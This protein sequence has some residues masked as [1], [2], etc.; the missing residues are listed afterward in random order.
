MAWEKE[1][2][3]LDVRVPDGREPLRFPA[4]LVLPAKLTW[5]RKDG[6]AGEGYDLEMD[7][8]FDGTRY[9]CRA[10]RLE[11]RDGGAPVTTEALRE[12]PVK[13][14][15]KTALEW[16]VLEWTGPP[17][18][19]QIARSR[20]GKPPADLARGGMT[21]EALRWVVQIHEVATVLGDPPTKS[22]QDELGI[23]RAT[24]GRWVAEARRRGMLPPADGEDS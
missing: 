17:G 6:P 9:V 14:M 1:H 22:V 20:P 12:V 23:S 21:D 8:A 24:A 5:S 7:I 10:L 4:G 18:G 16:A 13:R 19:V 15:I 2:W 11:Q 3:K